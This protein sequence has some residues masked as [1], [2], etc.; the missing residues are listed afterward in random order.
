MGRRPSAQSRAFCVW[1][2]DLFEDFAEENVENVENVETRI[3]Q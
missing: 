2:W 3:V 1:N